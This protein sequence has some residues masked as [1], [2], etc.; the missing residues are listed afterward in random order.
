MLIKNIGRLVTMEEKRGREGKLGV[1]TDAFVE[2]DG[3]KIRDFG[4]MSDRRQTA[5]SEGYIDAL[6]GVV[7]PG[8]V[9]CHT[10]LVHAGSRSDEFA[11]RARGATYEEIAKAGGGIMSTVKATREAGEEEL[12]RLAAARAVE[13][14]SH[15][16]TTVEVKSGYGLDVENELKMLRVVKRLNDDMRQEFV[17][18]FLG[19]HTVPMEFLPDGKAGRAKYIRLIVEQMLPRVAEEGLAEFCDVFVEK[20]AFSVDEARLILKAA[21]RYGLRSKVHADQLSP[22]GGAL[23]AAELR[24]VSADHLECLSAKGLLA[25]KKAKVVP[26]LIPTSTFF[27]GGRYAPLREMLKSGLEPA[28]STDYNPGTSPVLNIWM[29]AAFAITQM[30]MT[31]E[32]AYRGIT[33]NAAAALGRSRTHGSIAKGKVADLVILSS[34]SEYEPLYRFDRSFVSKVV[35]CGK[36]VYG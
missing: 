16:V 21:R 12:Y 19:A 34:E 15:G 32:R 29:A 33:I 22:S 27:I 1:I 35:K 7:I 17:P 2:V 28:V 36:V 14:L 18:T 6:G 23:L 25:M 8:L 10:H 31:A 24:A 3:C 4:R 13:L 30:K 26:V 20:I 9:E 5:D 11:A